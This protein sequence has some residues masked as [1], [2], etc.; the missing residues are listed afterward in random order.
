MKRRDA[1]ALMLAAVAMPLRASEGGAAT[2]T[3]ELRSALPQAELAGQA[4][5][6]FWGFEVYRARLW[7]APGFNSSDYAKHNFALE[8]TYLR[9]FSGADI[10]SRSIKEMRRQGPIAA[11][12]EAGWEA[13]MRT[14]FPDVKTN[15]RL[16]GIHQVGR[17]AQFLYNGQPL[18]EIRDPTFAK[19]FFGIWLAP[20]T[21]EPRMRSSLLGAAAEAP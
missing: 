14:L 6:S 1:A 11:A 12:Q 17:G 19:L 8:L 7:V 21:S 4:T 13:Q 20:Q 15:Q 16:T 18:G 2:Q 3:P 5:L 9:D 10:A